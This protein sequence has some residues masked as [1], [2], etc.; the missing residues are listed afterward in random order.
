MSR[1][2]YWLYGA[3]V[4]AM[5]F[6][7]SAG[8]VAWRAKN[9]YSVIRDWRAQIR[10]LIDSGSTIG[11]TPAATTFSGS[12]LEAVFGAEPE[13]LAQLK[14]LIDKGI[15]EDPSLS[16]GDVTALIVTFSKSKDGKISDVV[17]HVLGS[18][19][20]GKRRPGFNRDGFFAT[21]LDPNLWN[22]GN[23]LLGLLGRDMIVFADPAQS[24][25]HDDLMESVLSGNIF[26]LVAS[27]TNG[28]SVRFSAVFPEPKRVLPS[29]LRPHIQ[30][31]VVHGS[32]EPSKGSYETVFLTKESKSASYSLS[33]IS[34]LR[35]AAS[36]ALRNQFEG[37]VQ[38]RAWG[39]YVG[40][41]WAY[42]MSRMIENA[43]IEKQQSMVQ[44]KMD[45]ER[46][47]VNASLKA[48]E[49]MG[50][51]LTAMRLVMDEKLDPRLA[52]KQLKSNKPMHY[53]SDDHQW[54]P[55]WP[56]PP[57]GSNTA[58]AAPATTIGNAVA[59]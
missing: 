14:P 44:V 33:I 52:D 9:T 51:D 48:V 40:T 24:H 37:F 32:L 27:M 34:D 23:S 36:M 47:M 5:A 25:Q 45:F 55:D 19:S 28:S 43:S 39:D 13:L 20:I 16:L 8:Y 41:W 11:S 26:P 29:Q 49:R 38:K 46:P 6:V 10:H 50:R 21:Q 22:T 35:L 3:A 54:G 30:A 1:R 2:K 42:E 18:F 31:C 4:V 53:W 57:A 7:L 15:A 58:A 59:P 17:A 56:F 12:Y